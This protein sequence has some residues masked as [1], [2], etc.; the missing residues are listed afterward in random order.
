MCLEQEDGLVRFEGKGENGGEQT[1]SLDV[2]WFLWL[3][4]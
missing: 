2:P 4:A 3:E 1:K